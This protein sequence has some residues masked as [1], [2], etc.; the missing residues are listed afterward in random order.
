MATPLAKTVKQ[1]TKWLQELTESLQYFSP[2]CSRSKIFF[3]HVHLFMFLGFL[4][5]DTVQLLA[6]IFD[7]LNTSPLF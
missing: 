2:M 5:T 4:V 7:L 6:L 3:F 1:I